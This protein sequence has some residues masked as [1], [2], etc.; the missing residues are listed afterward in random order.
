MKKQN[1]TTPPLIIAHRGASFDAPE[2]TL[3]AFH[4]AWEQGADGIEGDFHLTADNEIV[5]MHD[6]ITERTTGVNHHI[7]KSTLTELKSLDVGSWKGEHYRKQAIPTLSEVL[8]IIP[9]RKY[10]F[11]EIK[12]GL[13]ILHPLKELLN[14][15]SFDLNYLVIISFDKEVIQTLKF[16]LPHIQMHLLIN[17]QRPHFFSRYHPTRKDIFRDIIDVNADGIDC[18]GLPWIVTK[19]FVSFFKENNYDVHVWTI[20]YPQVA[21]FHAKNGVHS[22]TTNRPEFIRKAL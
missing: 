10:F 5:C 4:L 9:P 16:E 3:A 6:P 15:T 18:K 8:A 2:N 22:I 13:E 21:S 19:N 14:Q 12:C 11:M 20:D 7:R 17:F 1:K